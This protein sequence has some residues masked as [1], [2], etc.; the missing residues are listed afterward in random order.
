MRVV[1]RAHHFA[2]DVEQFRPA[3]VRVDPRAVLGPHRPPV[4]ALR[5]EE[6]VVLL[7]GLPEDVEGGQRVRRQV[8]RA[9]RRQG[10]DAVES[11]VARRARRRHRRVVRVLAQGDRQDVALHRVRPRARP[12][13]RVALEA[14]HGGGL[15][16]LVR[17]VGDGDDRAVAVHPPQ[18][19]GRGAAFTTGGRG[20]GR[21]A[22]GQEQGQ[23]GGCGRGGDTHVLFSPWCGCAHL[24]A[25][26]PWPSGH[27]PRHP[28]HPCIGVRKT[29]GG[30]GSRER[31]FDLRHSGGNLYAPIGQPPAP[32]GR[33]SELLG[34]VLMLRASRREDRK[35]VPR[36]SSSQLPHGSAGTDVRESFGKCQCGAGQAPGGL[37]RPRLAVPEGPCFPSREVPYMGLLCR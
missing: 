31:V 36:Y 22:R 37:L 10:L 13:G 34:R 26:S 17:P 16:L 5:R 12:P 30:R 11:F 20:R 27:C 2:E 1:Q 35:R 3:R 21:E 28:A 23:G 6:G 4:D 7:E 8:G 19:F 9:G 25:S 18:A 24:C 14:A 32:Y 15:V 29:P 33:L